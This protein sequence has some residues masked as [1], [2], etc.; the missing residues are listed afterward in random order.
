MGKIIRLNTGFD[1]C[2]D[3]VF[4]S[5]RHCSG[6]KDHQCIPKLQENEMSELKK[7]NVKLSDEKEKQDLEIEILIAVTAAL[8]FVCFVVLMLAIRLA[9]KKRND[10]SAG[11]HGIRAFP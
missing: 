5:T 7:K 10:P 9:V 4:F 6:V 1:E 11:E 2:P 8:S 3:N